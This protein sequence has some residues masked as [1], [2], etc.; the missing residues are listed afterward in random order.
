MSCAEEWKEV[1]LGKN[2][3]F[4]F[5]CFIPTTMLAVQKSQS[6]TCNVLTTLSEVVKAPAALEVLC[7]SY[8][9]RGD[10]SNLLTAML[11]GRLRLIRF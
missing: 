11:E 3:K 7:R 1:L 8:Y 4:L 10:P 9:S 5:V 2:T 6:F